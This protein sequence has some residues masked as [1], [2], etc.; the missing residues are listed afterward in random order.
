MEGVDKG[1]DLSLLELGL[2]VM[3]QPDFSTVRDMIGSMTC[4]GG[5]LGEGRGADEGGCMEVGVFVV[6][7][8]VEVEAEFEFVAIPPGKLLTSGAPRKWI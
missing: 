4:G 2:G 8:V 3:M 1:N 7:E 6:K 5:W